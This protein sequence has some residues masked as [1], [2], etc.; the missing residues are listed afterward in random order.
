M[1]RYLVFVGYDYYPAG[2]WYDFEG[3]FD[4]IE[5]AKAKILSLEGDW[6]QVIDSENE[7]EVKE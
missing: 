7:Q 5:E 2:G 1:K 6:Y 4:S 3:S